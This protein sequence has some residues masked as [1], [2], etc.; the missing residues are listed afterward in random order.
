MW[1]ILFLLLVAAA[2]VGAQ[3][4]PER[5]DS[6]TA[7]RNL[8]KQIQ[9]TIPPLAKAAGVGG[10][11]VA[12]VTIDE[13]G[14]VR[15]V[16][17]ISGHPMLAPA[18]VET[19]KKWEYKPFLKDGKAASV[20]TRVEWTVESSKYS[21][22]QEKALHDYYPA[23]R[24][25]YDLVKQGK[26]AEGEAKCRA[27]VALSDQLPQNRILERSSARMFL[28]H[29]LYVQHK[30]SESI[31]LYENAVQIRK[32]HENSDRDADFATDNA[33]LARAYAAVGRLSE[34]D[35]YYSRAITIYKAAI[36]NL[37]EMKDNYARELKNAL[38]EYAKLKTAL[39]QDDQASEL[40]K[41]AAEF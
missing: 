10:T 7:S 37:P 30:F 29:S 33:S 26:A 32:S 8:T 16:T 12:D 19:V 18:F 39:G 34:S 1:R 20:I 31:P 17:L 40:E 21:S 35:L 15:S 38:L 22:S 3:D 2:S 23:F 41:E 25:C 5:I 4:K 14:K 27:V 28:A 36:A 9:P 11:V 24:E 13:S 6:A